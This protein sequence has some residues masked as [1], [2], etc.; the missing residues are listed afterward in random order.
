MAKKN[1]AVFRDKNLQQQLTC[2]PEF[3][4][5]TLKP[6]RKDWR[7]LS[8]QAPNHQEFD[9]SAVAPPSPPRMWRMQLE[10]LELQQELKERDH[11]QVLTHEA[12]HLML[13]DE[14]RPCRKGRIFQYSISSSVGREQDVSGTE[15]SLKTPGKV[16]PPSQH[17]FMAGSAGSASPLSF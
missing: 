2:F 1:K 17:I 4:S 10:V 3:G 13:K 14:C 6:G 11:T 7:F 12:P 8:S 16:C 9:R 5:Q 15:C